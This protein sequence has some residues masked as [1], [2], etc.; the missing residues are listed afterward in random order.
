[1]A[2]QRDDM[3]VVRHH[4]FFVLLSSFFFLLILRPLSRSFLRL[5]LLFAPNKICSH[6]SSGHRAD[7]RMG[8]LAVTCARPR[9]CWERRNRAGHTC[10]ETSRTYRA[11]AGSRR[12]AA[13]D[14]ALCCATRT[15][16][17]QSH[18]ACSCAAWADIP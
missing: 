4:F 16:I 11:A 3:F 18:D 10:C 8:R 5:C 13:V 7:G 2:A 12:Q 14:S 15:R 9:S 17:A 6:G 1:A